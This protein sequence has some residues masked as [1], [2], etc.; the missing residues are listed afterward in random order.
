MSIGRSGSEFIDKI[1]TI[2]KRVNK[3]ENIAKKIDIHKALKGFTVVVEKKSYKGI[4]CA[5]SCE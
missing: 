5:Y 2:K 3:R 1:L 4:M